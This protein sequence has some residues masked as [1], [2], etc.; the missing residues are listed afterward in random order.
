MVLRLQFSSVQNGIYA[1]GKTHMRSTSSLRSFH[2][3]TS[4]EQNAD[5]VLWPGNILSL[6]VLFTLLGCEDL[7]WFGTFGGI[8]M[9]EYWRMD[10]DAVCVCVCVCACARAY[11]RAC[12]CVR[13][14]V[15]MRTC[16]CVCVCVCVGV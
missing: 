14:C 7:P 11:V 4:V 9:L 5:S 6:V 1:L 10:V 2:R 15:C 8:G 12:A 3:L 13:T 16:V